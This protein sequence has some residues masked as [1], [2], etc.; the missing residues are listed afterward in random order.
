MAKVKKS[1]TQ[2]VAPTLGFDVDYI[3]KVVE[4][5]S[6]KKDSKSN[7]NHIYHTKYGLM[8]GDDFGE[9]IASISGKKKKL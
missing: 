2:V 9:Y 1:T 3:P 8:N 7:K 4:V 5:K 6:N